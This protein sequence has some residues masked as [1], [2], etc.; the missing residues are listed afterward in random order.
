MSIQSCNITS[1][2]Y[3][4]TT[5]NI[6]EQNQSSDHSVKLKTGKS[7]YLFNQYINYQIE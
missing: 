2:L 3:S 4:D 5:E 1:L 6:L 7:K